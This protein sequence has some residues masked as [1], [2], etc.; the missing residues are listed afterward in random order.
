MR[1]PSRTGPLAAPLVRGDVGDI[2][3][4]SGWLAKNRQAGAM[5][6]QPMTIYT[7]QR[8]PDGLES[9]RSVR[10]PSPFGGH[11]LVD[12]D[13]MPSPRPSYGSSYRGYWV[14]S[15]P[16]QHCYL[17]AVHRGGACLAVIGPAANGASAQFLARQWVDDALSDRGR[18]AET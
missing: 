6:R 14:S 5:R 18:V 13:R 1:S 4:V 17:G 9:T 3:G 8:R 12:L 15:G 2:L 11:I 16:A 10:L 7:E